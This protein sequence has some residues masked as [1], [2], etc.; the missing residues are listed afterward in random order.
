MDQNNSLQPRR[1]DP[2][3]YGEGVV[4]IGI[5]ADIEMPVRIA[6]FPNTSFVSGLKINPIAPKGGEE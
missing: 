3:F 4:Y 2:V 5:P 1:V 6:E